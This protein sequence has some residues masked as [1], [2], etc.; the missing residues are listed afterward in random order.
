MAP[1]KTNDPLEQSGEHMLSGANELSSEGRFRGA[2]RKALL[3]AIMDAIRQQPTDMLAFEA[4]RA[5]LNIRGQRTIGHQ[6]VPI[7][8]IIGS[9]GRYSDFDR[10]FLPRTEAVEDRWR[11][12]D[13]AMLQLRNLP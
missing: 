1:R 13:R 8:H 4:V 12:I 3:G 6:E 9:E 11:S 10:R 2:R 7:Q 5:C